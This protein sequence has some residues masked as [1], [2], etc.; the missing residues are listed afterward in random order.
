MDVCCGKRDFLLVDRSA[1]YCRGGHGQ[2][3]TVIAGP[4]LQS[5]IN[6]AGVEG[7]R[8]HVGQGAHGAERE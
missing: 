8:M 7:K 5:G 2:F 1:Q 3:A 4:Q 6:V